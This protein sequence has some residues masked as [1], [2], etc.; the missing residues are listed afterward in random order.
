MGRVFIAFFFIIIL[1][2]GGDFSGEQFTLGQISSAIQDKKESADYTGAIS[3]NIWNFT[4]RQYIL[5]PNDIFSIHVY[6]S[7]EFN[8]DKILIQPDGNI[9]LA[10]F[11]VIKVAGLTI[12]ELNEKLIKKYK[13]YLR[14]PKLTIKLEKTK[15]FIV[16]ITGAVMNP[17]SYEIDT[18]INKSRNRSN[19]EVDAGIER[20]TPLLSNLLVAA[21]GIRFDADLERVQI[22]NSVD[23]T[24][25]EIN[26]LD[27][28]INGNSNQDFY[29]MANDTVYVPKLPTPL[30]VDEE[31]YKQY[32]GATFSPK[33][34]PVRVY[35]YV[36]NPGLKKLDSS[37][38]ITLNSA[39]TAAGGYL[40]D[41]AYA[42]KKVYVSRAD[43]S[44]KLVT[45]VVNPMSNDAVLMPNDI[46]YIPEKPRPLAGKAFDY[47][48]R[49]FTPINTF[50]NTYNNWALMFNPHRYQYTGK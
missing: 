36:N 4:A 20:K 7:P 30:A 31:K 48:G 12:E 44:G 13:F 35:G 19:Q 46:V 9:V 43:V 3:D 16:Y 37:D 47:M 39:I 15:P 32:A 34:I 22:H 5:G 26:L 41:S 14:D 45:Q 29:L 50:A 2:S 40:K 27:F 6:D 28:L 10:P 24:H 49:I 42:P 8:Q 21:G 23:N 33:T 1:F 38:S 25:F 11:G 18:D 17:G